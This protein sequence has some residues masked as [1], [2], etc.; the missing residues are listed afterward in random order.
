MTYVTTGTNPATSPA[1]DDSE[2]PGK[3]AVTT[4]QKSV[5]SSPAT[6]SSEDDE[7][8]DDFGRGETKRFKGD[9]AASQQGKG[10]DLI[11]PNPGKKPDKPDLFFFLSFF[12]VVERPSA[13]TRI[14]LTSL[15]PM[16]T[17]SLP[18][19][20]MSTIPAPILPKIAPVNTF[21]RDVRVVLPPIYLPATHASSQNNLQWR[22]PDIS[23][24]PAL[25][26]I[27]AATAGA[28][29]TPTMTLEE[30]A[31]FALC[32]LNR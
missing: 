16:S 2:R 1:G 26:P 11:L 21:S 12:S 29:T 32:C 5:S 15:I 17:L 20:P 22:I 30:S 23:S 25:S 10:T 27:K 24:L 4:R 28:H 18:V 14:S 9:E 13:F 7:D 31:I 6:S 8:D 19:V 3:R